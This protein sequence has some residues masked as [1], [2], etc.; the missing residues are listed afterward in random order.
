M[1]ESILLVL[2]AALIILILFLVRRETQARNQGIGRRTEAALRFVLTFIAALAAHS[3]YMHN[4]GA[5][6]F[7]LAVLANCFIIYAITHL[8]DRLV[9]GE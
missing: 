6:S 8:F 4:A 2:A 3:V 1:N 9:F 5:F 7:W